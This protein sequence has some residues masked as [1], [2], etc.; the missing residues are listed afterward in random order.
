MF[1][2]IRPTIKRIRKK[3]EK[4]HRYE[5]VGGTSRPAECLPF[6]SRRQTFFFFPLTISR[7]GPGRRPSRLE[8]HGPGQTVP[9]AREIGNSRAGPGFIRESRHH[10]H[11]V[12]K[13]HFCQRCVAPVPF[14]ERFA[15]T[16]VS[17]MVPGT[18]IRHIKGSRKKT[19][20]F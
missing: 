8:S 7:A 15:H 1:L 16:S 6:E 5:V 14:R 13:P 20:G 9:A 11:E 2:P 3:K 18:G 19:A 17:Y 12:K 10:P 4:K